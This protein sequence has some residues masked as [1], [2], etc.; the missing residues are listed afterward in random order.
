MTLLRPIPPSAAALAMKPAKRPTRPPLPKDGQPAE[1]FPPLL[2]ACEFVPQGDG[3]Y[4]AVPRKPQDTVPAKE[5]ARLAN[6]PLTSI[7]RLYRAGFITG[8][9]K[10]PKRILINVASL[11]AHLE[12]VRD[13]EFWNA[14]RRL[15]YWGV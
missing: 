1:P 9:R 12:A 10:S 5:A 7:Y 8:E 2:T 6:F 15:R 4:R 14:E 13:P 3:T 11:Q